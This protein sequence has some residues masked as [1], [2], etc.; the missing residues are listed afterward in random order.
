MVL[1][2]SKYIQLSWM[3]ACR[4]Y[5]VVNSAWD[6]HKFDADVFWV[7]KGCAEKEVL[8]IVACKFCIGL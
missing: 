4:L 6:V 8:D 7:I 2:I 1:V 3:K 5:S